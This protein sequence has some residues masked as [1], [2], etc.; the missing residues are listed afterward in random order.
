MVKYGC[1]LLDYGT[2]L[3]AVSQEWMNWADFLHAH[4]YGVK[5]KSCFEYAHPHKKISEILP[6][7]SS[8]IVVLRSK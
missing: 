4:T 6:L 2:P 3:S 8:I 7:R 5:A 1:V